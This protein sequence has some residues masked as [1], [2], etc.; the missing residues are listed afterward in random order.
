MREEDRITRAVGVCNKV[1]QHVAHSWKKRNSLTEAQ[2][3]KE[4]PHHTLVTDCLTRWKSQHMMI[5][6][7][8]EQD[9]AICMVLSDDRTTHLIPT[10]QYMMALESVNAAVTCC[11]I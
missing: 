5:L 1:V 6:W 4:L 2:V 7:I 9:M 10:W 8:L 11:R 3:A